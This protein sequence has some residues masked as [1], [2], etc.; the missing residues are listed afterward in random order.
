MEIVVTNGKMKLR[1]LTEK[2]MK[3]VLLI[4]NPNA[5]YIYRI[6]SA[7]FITTVVAVRPLASL[8]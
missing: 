1:V 3:T 7:R 5:M 8:G 2:K 6:T 4:L